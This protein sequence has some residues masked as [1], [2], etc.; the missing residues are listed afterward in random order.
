MVEETKVK[1]CTKCGEEKELGE[2][3]KS[4]RGKYGVDSECKECKNKRRRQRY[5]EDEIYRGRILEGNNAYYEK[6]KE[7]ERRKKRE[8][9]ASDASVRER[10][11]KYNKKYFKERSKYSEFRDRRKETN[12]KW[13][14]DNK[15]RI[16]EKDRR[17]YIK[18]RETILERSAKNYRNYYPEN[19][20]I[21]RLN[22]A[23]RRARLHQLPDD[24]THKQ[25]ARIID[26]FRG[27]CALS[28]DTGD[29]HLDHVIPISIGHGGTIY[30]NMIPLRSDLNISKGARNLFDWF[31]DNRERFG[32]EQR[33]FDE[34]IEY[35]ANINDMTTQE[36]EE[37]VRWCHDNPREFDEVEN[38]DIAE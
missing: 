15:E 34:L 32:L 4:K 31:A 37:Y 13:R 36:Y 19:L 3:W 21:F 14:K 20:N 23:R 12:R 16:T 7:R 26:H 10:I 18:N 11:T 24:L 38:E 29:S 28:G 22:G 33:K 5:K 35:L 25:K 6:Y 27:A 8:E 17:Y 9:Y 2:Y 1:R 30:E